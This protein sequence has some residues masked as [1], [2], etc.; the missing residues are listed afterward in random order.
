[1]ELEPDPEPDL[2]EL[3]LNN[4]LWIRNT[5]IRFRFILRSVWWP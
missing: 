1:M 4:K 2:S 5:V 3:G